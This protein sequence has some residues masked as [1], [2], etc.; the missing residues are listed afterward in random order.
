MTESV[1]D[2]IKRQPRLAWRRYL[3]RG[4]IHAVGYTLLAKVTSEGRD[5]I[6][7][8]G[9][10][11]LM[12]SHISAIDPVIC[13]GESRKRYVVPMTKIE[14]THN[15]FFRFIYWAWGAY[16][17]HRDT[18]DRK[19]LTNSIEL[20]KSG[21]LILIAPEGTRH[22]EGLGE[23]KDGMVYIATKADAVI[24]PAAMSYTQDFKSRWKRF[25]RARA[26]V[27]FGRPFKFNINGR[28]HIPR[29]ELRLMTQEAMYQLAL[30]QAD[31]ALRGVYSD[32][33]NATT[34]TLTFL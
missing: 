14:N 8:E 26:H 3:L 28:T 27:T 16:S 17:V 33:E 34:H 11:I 7:A 18:V 10:C 20:L 2:Y 32:I 13:I 9:A 22:P 30:S 15:P 4:L 23:G 29:D 12:M 31:P 24:V 1:E 25:R 19:A 21:Q 5:N 6:P